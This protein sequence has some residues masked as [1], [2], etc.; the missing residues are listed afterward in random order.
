MAEEPGE[1]EIDRARGRI[2]LKEMLTGFIE[3]RNSTE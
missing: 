2:E 3:K 1:I